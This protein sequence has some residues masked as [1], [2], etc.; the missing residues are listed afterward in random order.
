MPLSI[1]T[2]RVIACWV[3]VGWTGFFLAT[4]R[5]SRVR[6]QGADA[7]AAA[8]FDADAEA[9][10]IKSIRGWASNIQKNRNGSVRFVRFSKSKVE[11]KHVASVSAFRR[12]DYLAVV[13]ESVDDGG[14][15]ALQTLTN[16]D[17]LCLSN[18]SIT[19]KT[20]ARVEPLSRLQRLYLDGTRVTDLGLAHLR[21][22]S[23]LQ[24]LEVDGEAITDKGV[25]SIATISSLEFLSLCNTSVSNASLERLAALP[26]LQV[27]M[28]RD[29]QVSDLSALKAF[30]KLR[31]VD[32]SGS[33]VDKP[34]L[35][36][37]AESDS[38]RQ[39]IVRNTHVDAADLTQLGV[40]SKRLSFVVSPEPT[41]SLG[42]LQRYLEGRPLRSVAGDKASA[43]ETKP[44]ANAR[45]EELF[46]NAASPP[47]FQRHVVPLLGRLGC[48]GRSCH[49]SFQGKGGFS[50]SMF[51]YDF[52]ADL[53]A[54][55]GQEGERIDLESPDESLIIQKPTEMESHEGGQRFEPN[56][57][58]HDVLRRWIAAG[59]KG[60]EGEP[61]KL[62]RL[63]VEPNEIVFARNP[64]DKIQLS[65]VAEWSDGTREDVTRL[66]RFLSKS[67][68]IV[69][70]SADGLVSSLAPGDTNVI[71]FYDSGVVAV[72]VL[73]PHYPQYSP[74]PK[75]DTHPIDRFV[76][77]KLAKLGVKPSDTCTDAEFLRRTSLDLIGTLP[78]ANEIR[79]FLADTSSDKRQRKID[80][81]LETDAYVEW[82]TMRLADLTGSNSQSL[83][84]T[85]MNSPASLQW[86][87]WL[88][89]RVKDNVGWDRIAAG[90][91][92]ASS[93]RPGQDYDTYSAEQSRHL[94]RVK[95]DDFTA[96]E[97]PMHY[98]WFRS[99]NQS[100]SDRALAFSFVFLGVRLECAQCHKHPFDQWSK[101]DFQEFTQFFTR[102][103]AG[104]ASESKDSQNHLK[105]K[106]GVPKKLD[107]A[108]LRRQMY[109]RVSAE[110][111]S[112]PWNEIWIQ[113]P[114]DK[115]QMARLLG[116]AQFDLNEF[117]DPREP[118]FQ[119]LVS[120]Q[121]PYFARAFVN[122]IWFQYFGRGLVDPSDDLN[123]ANPPSHPA[124]LDW[125]SRE[126]AA[127]KFDMK[128]LHRT[129]L[130]SRTYQRSSQPNDT[131]SHDER[132]YSRSV[133]RRLPAEVAIDSI[134]QATAA[135]AKAANWANDAASRKIAQHPRSF[136][137]RGIDYSLLVF[138]KPLRTTNC[139]C[140]RQLQPTLLQSIYRRNDSDML[141][142]LER[143]DGWMMQISKE[144]NEPLKIES[145]A[146]NSPTKK[147]AGKT[148]SKSNEKNDLANKSGD[149][150]DK[151]SAELIEAAYLRTLCR[152]PDKNEKQRAARHFVESENR[153]EALRDLLWA[154]LN[155]SEFITN[156]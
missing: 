49:G 134:L 146:A 56:G 40:A 67:D 53:K 82:W 73:R 71:A 124:M 106:L 117:E 57:W 92:L 15:E 72:P 62:I 22:N 115:P 91:I 88:R 78:T 60:R 42:L 119:W 114:G 23:S 65:C 95:P 59:A 118:L 96:L 18:S 58:E 32:A 99:N 94:A 48:N 107:T 130:N 93:R 6:A 74:S 63:V 37:L 139:D 111:L 68:A 149:E 121:N 28:I 155:T 21:D 54:I 104:V 131:N 137:A 108:A 36:S 66:T 5:L 140:E 112:I 35:M 29:T 3:V 148:P 79:E 47:S 39:V 76:D 31:L 46:S 16:L 12:I 133:I 30:P 26:N 45:A 125:L 41:E 150:V 105:N 2:R 102:I 7:A 129:I 52:D 145:K 110:G 113:P 61:A 136:Q 135:D 27:L 151:R 38:L 86:N 80:E 138:G 141:S 143:P 147:S 75:S 55:H 87:A 44:E 103:K 1:N 33:K 84:S 132:N 109:L 17:T 20:V 64:S 50:L 156:H 11:N 43:N 128:W 127:N 34:G 70:V 90:I 24:V 4:S 14:F 116:S 101:E 9:E 69:E 89:R 122:R 154:L 83:G 98:Y 144:L 13:T 142:W 126:F 123:L 10:A 153:V 8:D 152:L 97:K 51:G 85:D 100:P 25:E 81:L 77:T 19:D 120:K